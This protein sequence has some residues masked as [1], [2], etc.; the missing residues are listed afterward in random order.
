MEYVR[1]V[2]FDRLAAGNERVSQTLI[3]HDSGASRCSIN[4]IKTPQAK[5]RRRV[6]TSTW[7]TNSSTSSAARWAWKSRARDMRP[8]LGLLWC[9][10]QAFHIA[11]GTAA[12]KQPCTWPSTHPCR[13]PPYPS[14]NRSTDRTPHRGLRWWRRTI[15]CHL[16]EPVGAHL[17]CPIRKVVGGP[18]FEPGASRS[19]T[20]VALGSG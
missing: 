13:T 14:R 11:T 20:V 8:V 10:Q 6:S 5:V 1:K 4:C 9:F 19:R 16:R 17:R 7:S 12:A 2:D 15:A 18:G 3:G